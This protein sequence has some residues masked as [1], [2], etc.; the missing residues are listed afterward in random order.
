MNEEE[1]MDVVMK[2]F[3]SHGLDLRKLIEALQT[4]EGIYLNQ[5]EDYPEASPPRI[6]IGT[7]EGTNEPLV[8]IR[9]R[10][11]SFRSFDNDLDLTAFLT[12]HDGKPRAFNGEKK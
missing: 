11:H 12:T 4:I 3:Y 6:R 5:A 7:K 2:L 1:C 8:A 9:Q 10:L